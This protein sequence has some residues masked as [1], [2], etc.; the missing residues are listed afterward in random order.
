MIDGATRKPYLLE[1]NT[2]PGM[3]GHSLSPM[4]ALNYGLSF[5]YLCLSVLA[6]ASLDYK[7][8]YNTIITK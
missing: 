5:E 2:A 1:I 3:T 7:N 4:S 6:T 8:S